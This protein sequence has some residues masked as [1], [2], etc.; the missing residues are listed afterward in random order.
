MYSLEMNT[1]QYHVIELNV[2]YLSLLRAS[3]IVQTGL[4]S[5]V[6]ICLHS[7]YIYGENHQKKIM[8]LYTRQA[9]FRQCSV[10]CT[11][12]HVILTF[13]ALIKILTNIN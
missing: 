1:C 5:I 4:S 7:V 13:T 3:H 10:Q 9:I 6:I 8:E 11:L 12:F 2:L